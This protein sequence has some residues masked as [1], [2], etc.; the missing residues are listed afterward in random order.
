MVSPDN[1]QDVIH[2]EPVVTDED[3]H[4]DPTDCGG[5]E[6]VQDAL[7]TVRSWRL[8]RSLEQLRSQINARFQSRSKASDGTI[9]DAA[10]ATRSSDHNPWVVDSA[11]KGVV[12]AMDVSHDLAKG[13]DGN[14][15]AR[16][17]V[18]GSDPR[19]KY[20]IWNRRI[21][22]ASAIGS[23]PAWTWRAYTGANPHNHHLH[24]SVRPEASRYDDVAAWNLDAGSHE[25]LESIDTTAEVDEEI[26]IANALNTIG[27]GRRE[28]SLLTRLID[29]QAEIDTLLDLYVA[30][31]RAQTAPEDNALEAVKPGY[32]QLKAGYINLFDSMKVRP[33]RAGEVA[34]HRTKLLQFRPRYEEVAAQTGVPWWFVGIVHGLEGSFNFKAHLHNGDPLTARTVQVPNG[35]PPVWNPPSDWVSSAVDALTYQK[36]AHQPDWSLPKTL[37]RFE[38]YNG[39][40]YYARNINSPYLWSFSNHYTKGKFV[41]D[42]LYDPQA[43]SKQCG[44]AVMLRTMIDNEDVKV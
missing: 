27:E 33:E 14:W 35:R 2:E 19:I 25:S 28:A 24:L 3:G 38:G 20:I 26:L 10:H 16:T 15:L 36:H 4:A 42:G 32:D 18:A 29:A 9:G 7:E 13:I 37:H 39:F 22:S 6:A 40:G 41:R 1:V 34:W 44:A 30:E 5:S 17:L 11:G 31:Q 43:I 8:A 12:T 23:T 21:C